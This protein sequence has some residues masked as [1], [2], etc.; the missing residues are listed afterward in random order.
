[1]RVLA[2]LTYYHPHWTGLTLHA[3]R[4]AE[5]LAARGHEV[6]V[7]TT[8][9]SP[10]LA[11][12]EMV[13]GV[14]VVRLLP[15]LRL[16]RGMI[17]PAFPIAAARLI[18]RH[19]VVQIHTPLMESLLVASLCRV[20]RRPLVMTHHGDLIMPAGLKEK[21]VEWTVTA[22]MRQAGLWATRV[23]SYSKDYADNSPFLRAFAGKLAY[24]LPP[25]EIPE[26]R[27]ETVARWRAELALEGKRLVGFAGRFV[28]EKGFD[29]LLRAIPLVRRQFPEAHFVYAGEH[30]VVYEDF[31]RRCRSLLEANAEHLTFLGLIRDQQRLADFYGM[32]DAFAL[33]SRTDCLAIV[34]VESLLCG[35]PVVASDIP[36]ARVAVRETGGGVLVEPRSIE[37]LAEGICE[38]LRN[39]ER[40]RRSRE[41]VRRVFDSKRSLDKYEAVLAE[42][43]A[44]HQGAAGGRDARGRG[45]NATRPNASAAPPRARSPHDGTLERLLRNETDVAYRRRVKLI[46][47]YLELRQ[48]DA[49]LDCGCGMG[50]YLYAL[51]ELGQYRLLGYDGDAK[52]LAF[53]RRQLA[54]RGPTLVQ[55]GIEHLALAAGAVD[56]VICSEVLEHVEDDA[57]ALREIYRVLR[58]G[59]VLA[60]T[61]PN[62]AYPF[63]WDPINRMLQDLLGRPIRGGPLAGI[64][65]GH[66]RL[67]T[68][69]RLERAVREAGF[70][71]EDSRWL[72][73]YCFPF[74]AL[75][76][77]GIGKPL[78]QRGLL[79]DFVAK[80]THRFRGAENA[81]GRLNP[82]NWAVSLF[83]AF[84][85]LNDRPGLEES[86]PHGV[87]IALKARKP[88]D[89][90][91]AGPRA[92][93][94]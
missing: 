63:L 8:R 67:Y 24:V 94:I 21:I 91:G 43:V 17:T 36:G 11:R 76:V 41:E 69:A 23:T 52:S 7:L 47:N 34:Q 88:I 58:P 35:T 32:C 50:F 89:E 78:I 33:P 40:Y 46:V 83:T 79:P 56:K 68:R 81:G 60:L 44:E 87:C 29:Y 85:R 38:V 66:R 6:T 26:P 73:H 72:A 65:A 48:G 53:A 27:A 92:L 19:D 54:G 84:D 74:S 37:S 25:V 39:R 2:I 20:L 45:A 71:V 42:A 80:S 3:R 5:G 75:I 18:R 31:Y 15:A 61:V 1:M 86:N 64:W 30:N 62:A 12:D 14:R 10:D 93:S 55:G 49:V 9:H 70:V 4:V 28:E 13:N 22:M 16:S 77:Y 90:R 59:G 82:V 51:S 57:T